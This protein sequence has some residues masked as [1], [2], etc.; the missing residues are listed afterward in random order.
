MPIIPAF[1]EQKPSIFLPYQAKRNP[2]ERA[3]HP[4]HAGCDILVKQKRKTSRIQSQTSIM[5][6]KLSNL[7]IFWGGNQKSIEIPVVI[8]FSDDFSPW[9]F[10]MA[11]VWGWCQGQRC[12][13]WSV[14]AFWDLQKIWKG[15][16]FGV[17]DIQTAWVHW[18]MK[19]HQ[20]GWDIYTNLWFLMMIYDDVWDA[21][22]GILERFLVGNLC[23][24]C[25][26][27]CY[28]EVVH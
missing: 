11:F 26:C 12:R 17:A 22:I 9:W 14:G 3:N 23:K 19:K 6:I 25:V 5:Y 10:P 24:T 21:K 4:Q 28:W 1:W 20:K 2:S 16:T 15:G 18:G 8:F 13:A 27:H 7:A